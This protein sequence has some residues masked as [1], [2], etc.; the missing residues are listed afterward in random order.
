MTKQKLI[1]NYVFNT[2]TKKF[3]PWAEWILDAIEDRDIQI[4]QDIIN[5]WMVGGAK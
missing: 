3:Q 2:K 1:G 4:K 5:E